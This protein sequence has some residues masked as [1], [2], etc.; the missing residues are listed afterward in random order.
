MKYSIAGALL[1]SC[2]AVGVAKAQVIVA[3][4]GRSLG[5]VR[6]NAVTAQPAASSANAA[7]AQA[8]ADNANDPKQKRIQKLG[9]LQ[10]DRRPS[11]ILKAWS[12]PEP[13]PEAEDQ[14][15]SDGAEESGASGDAKKE[16]KVKAKEESRETAKDQAAEP[17]AKE[18]KADDEKDDSED[19]ESKPDAND[20]K[21]GDAE[22]KPD[23]EKAK[24]DAEAAE[25]E[26]KKA[27]EAAELAKAEKEFDRQ[28]KA[29]Q[30]HVTLGNWG[31]VKAF[32]AGLS[33]EE[34]KA[35]Y[36]RLVEALRA[37]PAGGQRNLDANR[38]SQMILN[39]A[40][41]TVMQAMVT[42]GG[43][44]PGAAFVETNVFSIA[45]IVGLI[46]AAPY[47]LE[48]E[49][50]AKFG[51]FVR[52]VVGAGHDIEELL[53][54]LESTSGD[55]ET[56]LLTKRQTAL[57]LFAAGQNVRAGNYLPTS[58]KA[59]EDDDR[60]ALNLLSRHYLA[61]HAKEKKTEHLEEA[62]K[63][64]QAVLAVGEV[65]QKQKEEAL[66][67]AVDL[68]PQIRDE[69]GEAWLNESF[70][71]RAERGREILAT[72]GSAVSM[73]LQT[74]P[75]NPD[76]RLKALELQH[77]AVEA[78]LRAAEET[79]DPWRET[80]NLLAN[81]WLKEAAVTHRF[82]QRSHMGPQWQRDRYGNYFYR[83]DEDGMARI[84]YPRGSVHPVAT[85]D[86]IET[87]PSEPWLALVDDS[88]KPKFSMTFSQLYLKVNEDAKA[89]PYIEQLAE[90]HPDKAR[91]LAHEF[92]RVWTRNHNPNESR[93]R[94]NPYM[95]IW[96]YQ[97][98][99]E[100]IPLTRS[101]QE[102]NLK[103]LAD[104]VSRLRALPLEELDE[105]LLTRA[106]TTSHSQAEVYRLETF[107]NVFGSLESLK[108]K[109]L[110]ALIQQ[111]RGNLAGVWRQPD[112]QKQNS[113][114]RK[115]KDIQAE[116]LRGYE[117]AHDVLRKG[118]EKHPDHWAL[119]LADA[120]I[121]HDEND[122]HKTIEK[123]SKF[124]ARRKEALAAFRRAAERYAETVSDLSEDEE[125]IEVYEMWFYAG[126]G[127]VDLPQINSERVPDL[128]QTALIRDAILALPGE[129]AERHMARFANNLFTRLSR[130]QA[131]LKFRYLRTGFEIAGD[132]KR[133][134]EARK[135]LDYYGD[136]V[137]EI[138]L[139]AKLDGG[140]TVGHTEPFGVFVNL[141]HT[142]EI[143]RESGGFGRYLQN[144]N[145][146]YYSYNYGRPTENYRDKFRDAATQ[147]LEEQFDV[148]SVTFSE[149]DV[150]S[151]AL[152]EYGWRET[153]YAYI[154]LKARGPEVDKLAPMR[155][156][157]DFLDTS[158]YAIIPVESPT[159]P[160]DASSEEA[161]PRPVENVSIVQ[162]LDE[163]QAD[164]GKLVLEVKV[165]ARGLVPPLEELLELDPTGFEI[166]DVQ[167][168]GVSVAQF[169]KQADATT[170]TSERLF[171]VTLRAIGQGAE[172]PTSFTFG[173]AKS[174]DAEVV[175]QRYVDADLADVG[176]QVSLEQQYG[177]TSYAWLGWLLGVVVAAPVA[178]VLWRRYG[179]K[180]HREEAA[181]FQ[182]P[183]HLT[184]FTV[185]GLLRDIQQNNGLGESGQRE[186]ASSIERLEQHYFEESDQEQPDLREI[187]VR[188]VERSAAR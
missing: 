69:L 166:T 16:S 7:Q 3:Q 180:P 13:D 160:I 25:A 181:R 47:E 24:A 50:F 121:A 21:S 65:D 124:S 64:T 98:R 142:K 31:E 179:T 106:F 177:E 108:P 112:V 30:R 54:Q 39:S 154:L 84:Q 175:Y 32:L 90:T 178:F 44:G 57:L 134:A 126:L 129:A 52:L 109:T 73:S 55:D 147:A 119:V 164:E 8:A 83:E 19:S 76:Y 140:D 15:E 137:T 46:A 176:R 141:V 88:F 45:D 122:F 105:S 187:A 89:F 41:P 70:T 174:D 92:L 133:A 130:V 113:T 75:T 135:V 102:R 72:I 173:T 139:E 165:T 153:P 68:A 120:A 14:S 5:G 59:L 18:A 40:D 85:G 117:V 12:E 95:Y 87:A 162:T 183:E 152:P 34:A 43:Q 33:E 86:L 115:Q 22:A 107:E 186:L 184:P 49:I 71:N 127:A 56:P 27:R 157:L 81:N 91:E 61:M 99:A 151:K 53:R 138:K 93:N 10:F 77:T 167:D 51:T 144:Q 182:M 67:R 26:A 123:S 132:H 74:Y 145:N 94:Y 60:E 62:W 4:P 168:D 79:T 101:K 118:L 163:R 143:E 104:L 103:E 96:G 136:L 161:P 170:I 42:R 159:V 17:A 111:M 35:G 28:L 29:F 110:A 38:L 66:K 80:L 169:D 149:P 148:L 185:L 20:A 58:E 48:K 131:E 78:L 36:D 23:P 37:G 82:D 155:L 116:V 172:R 128:H 146:Q 171:M 9:Q 156:D 114:N 97:R 100:K 150:N 188:W 6:V 158:G 2:C 1:L 63:A 125:S 11:S